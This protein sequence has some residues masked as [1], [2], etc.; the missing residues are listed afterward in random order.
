MLLVMN[1]HQ[2]VYSF[3]KGKMNKNE[4]GI[5]CAKREVWEEVGL[6]ISKMISAKD[7]LEFVCEDTGQPQRMYIISGVNENHKFATSTRYEIGAIHWVKL[8]EIKRRDSRFVYLMPFIQGLNK[9]IATKSSQSSKAGPPQPPK[10]KDFKSVVSARVN[11]MIR[12]FKE[13]LGS[14]E[15]RSEN[16]AQF[17]TFRS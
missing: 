9:Y 10:D 5:D 3:P 15:P 8:S 12:E 16:V 17:E 6:D 14:A 11:R 2:T 7:Y 1:Y 13:Q 4:A